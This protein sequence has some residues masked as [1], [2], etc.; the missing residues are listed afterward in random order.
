MAR[1]CGVKQQVARETGLGL[2]RAGGQWAALPG[3]SSLQ[4]APSHFAVLE[5]DTQ[6]PE[7]ALL[8]PGPGT[9]RREGWKENSRKG[10]AGGRLAWEVPSANP[11]PSQASSCQP[12]AVVWACSLPAGFLGYPGVGWGGGSQ[13]VKTSSQETGT[14]ATQRTLGLHPRPLTLPSCFSGAVPGHSK[15]HPE[16]I[17]LGW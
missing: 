10:K 5:R 1:R 12:Q 6:Y 4:W 9:D 7:G 8:F 3:L 13:G 2:R 11:G 15:N 14:A 16:Q 17:S